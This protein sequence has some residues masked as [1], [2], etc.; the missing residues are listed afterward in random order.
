MKHPFHR[1]TLAAAVLLVSAAACAESQPLGVDRGEAA[2]AEF[3]YACSGFQPSQPSAE[4]VLADIT[5]S[6]EVDLEL[7]RRHGGTPVYRF[8]VERVRAVIP[9]ANIPALADAGFHRVEGVTDRADFSVPVFVAFPD[10]VTDADVQRVQALGAVVTHRYE[11]IPYI[12]VEID[13]RKIPQ[14][15]ALPR[16]KEIEKVGHA[17]LG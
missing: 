7:V 2:L 12:A 16:V 1:R 14:L 5:F 17:C 3:T 15:R 10:A 8:H 9:T 13:D 4:L 6:G 11:V